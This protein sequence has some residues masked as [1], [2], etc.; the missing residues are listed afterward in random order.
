[1]AP[2]DTSMI[3]SGVQ[4]RLIKALNACLPDEGMGLI[5]VDKNR[6]CWASDPVEYGRWIQ[7]TPVLEDMI[8]RINDGDEP[9]AMCAEGVH[10][11]GV[12]LLTPCCD[13]GYA[14]VVLSP[15]D[16]ESLFQN[17]DLIECLLRQM[18]C[19]AGLLEVQ[20]YSMTL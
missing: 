2:Y 9:A 17:W 18:H 14:M 1:M 6:V 15:R 20:D 8:S 3:D 7:E 10:M 19:I 16:Q 5:L 4:E 11:F 12:H 13:Y